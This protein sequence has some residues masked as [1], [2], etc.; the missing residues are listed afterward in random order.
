[1]YKQ[2]NS[3]KGVQQFH[4]IKE[5]VWNEKGFEM[6]YA[7]EGSDIYVMFTE[8]GEAGGT[9]EFT[10][11]AKI[12]EFMK[13]LFKDVLEDERNVMELDSV[14]VL[15]HARGTLGREIICLMVDYA[16]KHEYSHVVAIFDPTFFKSLK[17]SYHFDIKQVKDPLYYKGDYVIPA[18]LNVK[19]MYQ[20]K[21]DEKFL[22][23]FKS[24]KKNVKT[25]ASLSH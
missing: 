19:D 16:E 3:S 15:P 17:N 10:P 23:Y 12:S 1:M 21:Q 14:A 20:N 18:I 5:I 22:W 11:Y 6:E 2:V 9:V 25:M 13:N 24:I 7:K 8:N 4:Q